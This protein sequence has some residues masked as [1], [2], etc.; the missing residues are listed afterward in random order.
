MIPK[1]EKHQYSQ[2]LRAE[3]YKYVAM[4]DESYAP[5]EK[6]KSSS[7]NKMSGVHYPL[8]CR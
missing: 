7:T 1:Q 6:I 2:T 3:C 5:F 4:Q 8:F